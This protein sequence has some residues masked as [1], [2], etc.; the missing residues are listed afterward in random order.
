MKRFLFTYYYDGSAYAFD[1]P[2][3]NKAEAVRRVLAI[4]ANATYTGE[5]AT[6]HDS[7]QV[8]HPHR[9]LWEGIKLSVTEWRTRTI[10]SKTGPCKTASMAIHLSCMT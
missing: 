8:E 3:E 9:M 1:V 4:G 10:I 6:E 5:L 7:F 2:A